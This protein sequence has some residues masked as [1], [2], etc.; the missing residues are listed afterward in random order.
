MNAGYM[1][2]LREISRESP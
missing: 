1:I 2:E